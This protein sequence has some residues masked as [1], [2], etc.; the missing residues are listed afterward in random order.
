MEPFVQL[1]Q[2]PSQRDP[3]KW[4]VGRLALAS[5]DPVTGRASCVGAQGTGAWE[6]A[7]LPTDTPCPTRAAT[8]GGGRGTTLGRHGHSGQLSGSGDQVL[9]LAR[10]IPDGTCHFS[11]GRNSLIFPTLPGVVSVGFL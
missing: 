5:S 7:P 9:G 3:A 10:V 8:E 11:P 4:S 1:E 2:G 6:A